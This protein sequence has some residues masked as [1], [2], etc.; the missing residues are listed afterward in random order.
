MKVKCGYNQKGFWKVKMKIFQQAHS[1][2][3]QKN[4]PFFF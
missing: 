1:H 2:L 3:F 4:P